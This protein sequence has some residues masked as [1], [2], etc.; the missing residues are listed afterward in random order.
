MVGGTHR[1]FV[2]LDDDDRVALIAQVAQA[3]QQQLVVARMQPDRRLIEDVHDADQPATDL[4]SQP[5][6]LRLPARKR[7]S[8]TIERQVIQSA[9]QQKPNPPT[10]LF[11]HFAGDE[12]SCRV[13]L[14]FLEKLGRLA[15]AQC[16]D[17]VQGEGG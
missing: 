17:F 6:A 15:D 3:A 13:E 16:A 8:R 12:L 2:M 4:P 9:T 14:Q 11:E 10:N 5:N 1:F 7:R